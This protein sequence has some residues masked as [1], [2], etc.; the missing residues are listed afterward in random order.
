MISSYRLGDLF[1]LGLPEN[2]ENDILEDHPNSIAS[3]YILKKRSMIYGS[4]I[5]AITEIILEYI[6][7]NSVFLPKDISESTVIHVRLGDV[8]AGNEWHEISK[9]PFEIEY[10]KSLLENDTNKK[11]VIG[12]CFFAKASSTNYEEC[13][14]KSNTYLQNLISELGAEHFDSGNPDIDLCCAIK[15]KL[16][17]QGRGFYSRLIVKIR[18]KLGLTSIETKVHD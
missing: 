18:D 17:V 8:V 16:F 13:I 15:S 11:Y 12:K 14:E 3:K 4:Y 5:D 10:I 6:K 7:E 1:C 9:R 2:E